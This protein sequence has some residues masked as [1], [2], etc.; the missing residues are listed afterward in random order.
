MTFFTVTTRIILQEHDEVNKTAEIQHIGSFAV[1]AE[2]FDEATQKAKELMPDEYFQIIGVE[3][4]L[5]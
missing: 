1:E 2:N 4:I 3:E 5:T